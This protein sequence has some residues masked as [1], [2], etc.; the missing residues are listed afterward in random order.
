VTQR[1]GHGSGW[2]LLI[3]G[4]IAAG[5]LWTSLDWR[6]ETVTAAPLAQATATPTNT[7]TPTPT[8][9]PNDALE[10]VQGSRPIEYRAVGLGDGSDARAVVCVSGCTGGSAG[11]AVGTVVPVQ[12]NGAV[13]A[14]TPQ[15]VT[16]VGTQGPLAA[17]EAF[18]GK[19]G[20]S[21]LHPSANPALTVAATY[22]SGDFVGTSATPWSWTACRTSG[23]AFQ[24]QS[25]T[26]VD[27]ASQSIAGEVWLFDRSIT[28][29]NDSAA[30]TVTD[31]DAQFLI[32]VIPTGTYYAS[33]AN[34]VAVATGVGLTGWCNSGTSISGAFVTRGSPSYASGDLTVILGVVTD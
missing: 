14:Q 34:T 21:T 26:V 17:G 32:G 29:P 2:L 30:W 25:M 4:A 18:I 24:V 19:V 12:P 16:V 6:Q 7:R 5:C 10:S 31:A 1:K 8:R 23:G 15:A 3:L 33:A 20:G 28:V 11:Y 27:K 22:V 9:N 13:A